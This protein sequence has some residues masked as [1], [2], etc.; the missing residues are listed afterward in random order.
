[1]L[2][3]VLLPILWL[4]LLLLLLW[5]SVGVN[6][7]VSLVAEGVAVINV[8]IVAVVAAAMV[9][10]VVDVVD[11]DDDAVAATQSTI[12]LVLWRHDTQ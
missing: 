11:D 10:V 3:L 1:M 9:V 4:P 12:L 6:F 2:W 7:V 5:F 8:V